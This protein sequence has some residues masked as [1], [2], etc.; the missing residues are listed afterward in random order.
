MLITKIKCVSSVPSVKSENIKCEYFEIQA[1]Q[2]D[3]IKLNITRIFS[4]LEATKS[5]ENKF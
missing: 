3:E 4:A 5:D 2:D 1:G